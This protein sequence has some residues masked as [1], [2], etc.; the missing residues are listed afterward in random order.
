MICVSLQFLQP[1]IPKI[2]S[3]RVTGARKTLFYFLQPFISKITSLIN[4]W[5]A[6]DKFKVET[7]VTVWAG[8]VT[9]N[10][11]SEECTDDASD[12]LKID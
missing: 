5:L 8:N 1:I 9:R 12:I 10:G 11:G 3:L 4:G 2:T 7:E 6:R